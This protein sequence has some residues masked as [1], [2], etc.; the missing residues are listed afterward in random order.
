MRHLGYAYA[1]TPC[2]RSTL[3]LDGVS[4][5]VSGNPQAPGPRGSAGWPVRQCERR[6]TALSLGPGSSGAGPPG[7]LLE[8]PSAHLEVPCGTQGKGEPGF[9]EQW[10]GL[11]VAVSGCP[12]AV[13]LGRDRGVSGPQRLLWS[14]PCPGLLA[15]SEAFPSALSLGSF[16]PPRTPSPWVGG[17]PC[18]SY[19]YPERSGGQHGRPR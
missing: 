2:C 3:L 16:P 5:I 4:C 10:W 9:G 1:R 19:R 13:T 18:H 7:L 14:A 17:G 15:S 12:A 6:Q 11:T 8:A